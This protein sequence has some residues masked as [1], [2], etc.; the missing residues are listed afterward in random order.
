M[1]TQGFSHLPM[2]VIKPDDF[3]RHGVESALKPFPEGPIIK[4]IVIAESEV[5]GFSQV[6]DNFLRYRMHIYTI[7][8]SVLDEG[9]MGALENSLRQRLFRSPV[10][11]T[12][13]NF[14]K[15]LKVEPQKGLRMKYISYEDA[16]K[17]MS[18][19]GRHVRFFNAGQDTQYISY[20]LSFYS[21][22]KL[23]KKIKPL[24]FDM[25][26]FYLKP[27]RLIY[28]RSADY[29]LLPVNIS[30]IVSS[31]NVLSL[32]DRFAEKMRDTF[33]V[34]FMD[35]KIFTECTPHDK[36]QVGGYTKESMTSDFTGL[37]D[38][39]PYTINE[40][41]FLDDQNLYLKFPAILSHMVNKLSEIDLVGIEDVEYLANAYYYRQPL[42]KS[43]LKKQKF[44]SH[45]K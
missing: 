43:N 25:F 14:M 39:N 27:M 6:S 17:E 16:S 4:G 38:G 33:M 3:L 44:C 37:N 30:I 40:M 35:D 18:K 34:R 5:R 21:I 32:A 13:E 2:S 31:L 45:D 10:L 28:D 19:S 9:M 11:V 26:N 24:K 20:T 29:I 1:A 7:N 22:F 36:H 23:E 41:Q 15:A 42:V 8:S 12:N